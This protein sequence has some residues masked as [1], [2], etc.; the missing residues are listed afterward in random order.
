MHPHHE[1]VGPAATTLEK[2]RTTSTKTSTVNQNSENN[3]DRFPDSASLPVRF[4]TNSSKAAM[5]DQNAAHEVG[6]HGRHQHHKGKVDDL[7]PVTIRGDVGE[8]KIDIGSEL[9]PM[10]VAAAMGGILFAFLGS[11]YFYVTGH[12]LAIASIRF[13]TGFIGES[14]ICRNYF[15]FAFWQLIL[16]P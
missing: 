4:N 13:E 1:T 2:D 12:Q 9:D 8:E 6:S 16:F 11:Y 15:C 5:Y 7:E 14:R 10:A 3:N